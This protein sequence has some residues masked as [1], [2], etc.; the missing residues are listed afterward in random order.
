MYEYIYIYISIYI[1]NTR[2][3]RP[4]KAQNVHNAMGGI[5]FSPKFSENLPPKGVTWNQKMMG[6]EISGEPAVKNFRAVRN[7]KY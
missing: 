4:T 1:I 6:F 3:I 2:L 7:K 5:S